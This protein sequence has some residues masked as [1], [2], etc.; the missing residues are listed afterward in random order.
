M[1]TSRNRKKS[2]LWIILSII[3][4]INL[5][6]PIVLVGLNSAPDSYYDVS[7]QENKDLKASDILP[8][9]QYEP[10]LT[11]EK[12]ALGTLNITD[13]NF[14]K[15]GYNSSASMSSAYKADLTSGALTMSYWGTSFNNTV[16]I[17]QVDNLNE[18]ITDYKKIDIRLNESISVQYDESIQE[19]EGY[20]LYTPRLASL[21]DF[22]LWIENETGVYPAMTR[23]IVGEG[24]YSIVTY[25]GADFLKFNY[26][27]FFNDYSSNNFTFHLLWE[28]EISIENWKLTQDDDQ[29]ILLDED[30]NYVFNPSF[31]YRFNI[32]GLEYNKT[33]SNTFEKIPAENLLVNMSINLPDKSQ[34]RNHI[35]KINS[36]KITSNFFDIDKS[37]FFPSDLVIANNSLI[38]IDFTANYQMEFVEA[39]DETWAIDRLVE[40]TDIR[41]RIYFPSLISGPEHIYVKYVY[42]IDETISYNQVEEATSQFGRIINYEEV[43]VTEF[44][45]DI[46]YSLIFSENA[47]KRAGIMITLPYIIKNEVCPFTIKYETVQDL[48]VIITDNIR[49]PI[50]GLDVEIY[51]F[52]ELY[53]SYISKDD[54]QPIGKTITN[55]NGEIFV[56]N[57]PN[58]NYTIKIYQGETEIKEA[59]VSSYL[60]INYVITQVI[61][62]PFIILIYSSISG[63]IFWLGLRTY[64]KQK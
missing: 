13:L 45:E 32:K 6:V 27:E 58:G 14:D 55:E 24:N 56:K 47:T 44:E 62:F 29:E 28:Y 54:H 31:S 3:V 51:Y 15:S 10:I 9:D 61:H 26:L 38:T 34:L 20:L 63:L 52:G 8:K 64:R 43:N 17:A 49:M 12:Q 35:L 40:D 42:I 60:E 30:E 7:S 48:R 1:S 53:G 11:G 2:L 41:E 57:V 19:V 18:N 59:E 23:Q 50:Q 4:L 25:D 36:I 33:A 37:I 16:K 39:V 22:Q 5:L 46:E 21:S